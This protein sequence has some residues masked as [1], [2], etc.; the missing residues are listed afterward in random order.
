[1]TY[2]LLHPFEP[3]SVSKEGHEPTNIHCFIALS[4]TSVKTY[5]YFIVG[6]DV[7]LP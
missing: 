2:L 4:G 1:M 3:D 6:R 7:N 5:V